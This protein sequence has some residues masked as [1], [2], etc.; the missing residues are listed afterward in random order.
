MRQCATSK[1]KGIWLSSSGLN[2]NL[3]IHIPGI[4]KPDVQS[5]RVTHTI[6][7][8][9]RHQLGCRTWTN[10]AFKAEE[11][12]TKIIVK[13]GQPHTLNTQALLANL[14]KAL[15]P[16]LEGRPAG[17]VTDFVLSTAYFAWVGGLTALLYW[18]GSY[19]IA[20]IVPCVFLYIFCVCGILRKPG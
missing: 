15:G 4:P 20:A 13:L 5:G 6:D 17:R 1:T 18:N 2:Q 11:G 14:E 8:V 16:C 7:T 12:F 10:P 19:L 9:L 3:E